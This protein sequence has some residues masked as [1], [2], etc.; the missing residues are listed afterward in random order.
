MFLFLLT[1]YGLSSGKGHYKQIFIVS[2]LRKA[3]TVN[4][5]CFLEKKKKRTINY[6]VSI[7]GGAV[8]RDLLKAHEV[9]FAIGAE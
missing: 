4:S 6:M 9:D 7:C 2:L 1:T 3:T 5:K 8:G